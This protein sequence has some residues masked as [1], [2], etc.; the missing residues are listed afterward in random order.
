[1]TTF[2]S[3]A[4]PLP[5]YADG[6]APLEA[7]VDKF[8]SRLEG[9]ETYEKLIL[10]ATIATNLAYHATNETGE[11]WSL[12]DT[13]KDLPSTTVGNELLAALDSLDTLQRDNI[14][15]LCEALVAQIRYSK[16]VA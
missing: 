8:G 9:L 4:K 5:F 15:G 16:E 13:Y 12:L 10:L 7:L 2:S 14:L 6:E 11:E 3:S 1:M